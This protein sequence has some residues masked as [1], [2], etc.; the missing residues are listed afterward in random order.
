MSDPV[1]FPADLGTYLGL[2]NLDVDRAT[3]ILGLA[4]ALCESV[5]SPLPPGAE[6]VVLDVASQAWINPASAGSQA[7][8]PFSVGPTPGGLRLTRA[9]KATLR[10]L[11]GSGGAFTIDVLPAAAATD[12]PWWD[13]GGVVYD[14]YGDYD[15]IP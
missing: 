9:N 6:A 11:A 13:A 4:Q 14:A 5:V 10:R 3:Q 8:G 7:A 1:L 2:P 15:Q 12:M